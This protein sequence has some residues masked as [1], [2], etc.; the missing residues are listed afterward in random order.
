MS[1]T[2]TSPP[3]VDVTP[4]MTGLG[5]LNFHATAPLSASVA[6][7]QPAHVDGGSSLPNNSL[8][9][10]ASFADH[11]WYMA[12]LRVFSGACRVTVLHQSTA[13]VK[14]RFVAGS[15]VGPFH[16]EPPW[17]P[18]QK[19]TGFCDKGAVAF[20]TRVTGVRYRALPL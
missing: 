8:G 11:A 19:W 2:N 10:D 20:S 12:E 16:S 3:A 15:Y 14:S 5:A 17:M 6:Y 13:P 4:L 18:G 1:P 9:L 7:T